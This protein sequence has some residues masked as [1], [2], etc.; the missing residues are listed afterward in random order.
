MLGGGGEKQEKRRE[1]GKEDR[2]ERGEVRQGLRGGV[3][4]ED[5]RRSGLG[6]KLCPWDE[7]DGVGRREGR[8]RM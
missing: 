6:K 2:G 4:R 1:G 5:R 8:K 7:E 3:V